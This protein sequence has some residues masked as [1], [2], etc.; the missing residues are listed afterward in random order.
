VSTLLVLGAAGLLQSH[1]LN[2][3]VFSG[4]VS[5]VFAT[6]L[7]DDP[8]GRWEFGLKAFGAF[9]LGTLLLGWVMRPFPS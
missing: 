3:V 5:A 7:R 8:R 1:L 4:L 9:V 2:L 6:L